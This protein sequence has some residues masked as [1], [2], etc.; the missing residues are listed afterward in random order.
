[1]NF[2]A[3]ALL[4]GDDGD[5]IAGQIAGDFVRGRLDRQDLGALHAGVR[6]H[7]ALDVFT[8]AHPLVVRSRKRLAGPRRR[9]A[10][11]IV[12]VLYDHFLA[13]HW[14][15]YSARPL[16]RF[17]GGVYRAL[18]CR[19]ALLPARLQRFL[20][21]MIERDLLGGIG[22]LQGLAES[23]ARLDRRFSR[24]TPLP[25][26]HLALAPLD[27]ALEADFLAFFPEAGAF[28]QQLIVAGEPTQAR[29]AGV[30]GL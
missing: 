7:R 10:G 12:D 27:A 6:M 17:S 5:L 20:P 18:E 11:I 26:S 24:P 23:F 21:Y 9:Y 25:D 19:H 2:L 28:A 4:A 8:D 1:M 30:N 14:E 16:D 29:A 22:G 3:H 15:R 13:R